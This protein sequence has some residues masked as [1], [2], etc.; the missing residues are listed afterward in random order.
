M[1]TKRPK[2]DHQQQEGD[3]DQQQQGVVNKS[4]NPSSIDDNQLK[5]GNEENKIAKEASNKGE[6]GDGQKKKVRCKNWPNCKEAG[7]EYSH[8]TQ[9]VLMLF[10]TYLVSFLSKLHVW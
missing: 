10:L 8:P 4:I 1:N 6:E 9:T 7:C 3:Q 2:G 5:L